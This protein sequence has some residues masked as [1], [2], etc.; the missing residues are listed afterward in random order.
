MSGSLLLSFITT[1]NEEQVLSLLW[2]MKL[3]YKEDQKSGSECRVPVITYCA[4]LLLSTHFV[5]GAVLSP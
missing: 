3:R 4:V 2:I 5:P 1:L